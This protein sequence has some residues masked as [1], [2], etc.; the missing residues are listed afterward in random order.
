MTVKWQSSVVV[1]VE[2]KLTRSTARDAPEA[3]MELWAEDDS[4]SLVP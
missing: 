2:G 1:E 4:Q 3:G